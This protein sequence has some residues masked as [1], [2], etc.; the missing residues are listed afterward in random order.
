MPV[1]LPILKVLIAG[2]FIL[3]K[4]H[5]YVRDGLV[6]SSSGDIL[7]A[8]DAPKD[9]L[10]VPGTLV[11]DPDPNQR[12]RRWQVFLNRCCFHFLMVP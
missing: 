10:S 5:L 6:E 9:V 8:L 1:C 7:E 12:A 2:L 4:T 11:T 3:G